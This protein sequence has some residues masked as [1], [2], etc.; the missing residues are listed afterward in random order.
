MRDRISGSQSQT[1]AEHLPLGWVVIGEVCIVKVH[2]PKEVNVNKTNML[3][4]GRCDIFP[5]RH[6]NINVKD[7]NFDII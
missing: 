2:P 5:V 6:N 3:N 4:D 7:N 1:F